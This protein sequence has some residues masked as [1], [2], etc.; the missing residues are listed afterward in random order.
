MPAI[1]A[2]PKMPAMM[3][4]TRNMIAHES[5]IGYTPFIDL[6]RAVPEKVTVPQTLVN[7]LAYLYAKTFKIIVN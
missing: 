2:K 5:N 7:S 1:P 6:S 4:I 3:A